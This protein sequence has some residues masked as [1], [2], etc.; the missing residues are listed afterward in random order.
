MWRWESKSK[1]RRVSWT[2]ICCLGIQGWGGESRDEAQHI[3]NSGQWGVTEWPRELYG[4][5]LAQI[6]GGGWSW[7]L[8]LKTAAFIFVQF[9]SLFSTR[10]K[11]SSVFSLHSGEKAECVAGEQS[12]FP[13]ESPLQTDPSLPNC[14][15]NGQLTL[16]GRPVFGLMAPAV[17]H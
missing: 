16:E 1:P 8:T 12:F 11:T 2:T 15:L 4:A 10:H 3:K 7:A 5:I 6:S 17:L 9:T 13:R 14:K